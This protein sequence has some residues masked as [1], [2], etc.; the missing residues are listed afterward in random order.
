MMYRDWREV[1]KMLLGMRKKGASTPTPPPKNKGKGADDK[2]ATKAGG[3]GNAPDDGMSVDLLPK[4]KLRRPETVAY[5]RWVIEE[6]RRDPAAFSAYGENRGIVAVR[7]RF[8]TSGE[9]RAVGAE[10]VKEQGKEEVE[11][12][13]S[14]EGKGKFTKTIIVPVAI[15]GCGAFRCFP[16]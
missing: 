16:L 3:K 5:A 14:K 12:E 9:G 8:L 15:P 7:E 10:V 13:Q 2:K 6:I 1:T 11:V 4:S